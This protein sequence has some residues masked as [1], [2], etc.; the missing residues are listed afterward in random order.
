MLELEKSVFGDLDLDEND[1]QC[2]DLVEVDIDVES[3]CLNFNYGCFN[4]LF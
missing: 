4:Y 2:E 1:A 3:D